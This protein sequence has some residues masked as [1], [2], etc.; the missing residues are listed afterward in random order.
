[1]NKRRY[2]LLAL[3]VVIGIY[4]FVHIRAR[5]QAAANSPTN[6]QISAPA[7]PAAAAAWTAYDHAAS[8]RDAN[9]DTFHPA[10][11][12][13]DAAKANVA[14]TDAQGFQG[15]RIWLV[16]YRNSSSSMHAMAIKHTDSCVKLHRDVSQ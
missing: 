10:L 1:M 7:S 15:C 2:V 4:D 16:E 6:V 9:T 12:A 14:T 5:K 11:E 3:L 13:F 8:L